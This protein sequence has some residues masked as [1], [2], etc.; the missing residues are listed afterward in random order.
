M[1]LRVMTV[2]QLKKQCMYRHV[3]EAGSQCSAPQRFHFYLQLEV[4]MALPA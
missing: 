4:A 3:R 1:S 2:L